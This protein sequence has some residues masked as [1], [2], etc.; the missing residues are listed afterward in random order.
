[1]IF[2]RNGKRLAYKTEEEEIQMIIVD[3]EKGRKYNRIDSFVFSPDEKHFTYKAE[4][5]G[6]RFVV[7]NNKEGKAYDFISPSNFSFSSDSEY[8]AYGAKIGNQIWRI[9]RNTITGLREKK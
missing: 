2:S 5:N 6:Q 3:N 9:T 1:M 8:I 7:L 4:K